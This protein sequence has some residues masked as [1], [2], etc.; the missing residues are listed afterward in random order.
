MSLLRVIRPQRPFVVASV[1]L[2][3]YFLS[4]CNYRQAN[5]SRFKHSASGEKHNIELNELSKTTRLLYEGL[6]RGDRS[7]LARS[8]TLVEST[9]PDKRSEARKLIGIATSHAKAVGLE[10]ETF[11]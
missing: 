5:T 7:S 2:P 4:T 6:L 9:H 1:T 10:T 11:R 3:C 8:I